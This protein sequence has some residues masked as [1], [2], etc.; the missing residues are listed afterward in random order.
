M[1]QDDVNE[2]FKALAFRSMADDLEQIMNE[3]VRLE[4]Q[5]RHHVGC[6]DDP[7]AANRAASEAAGLFMTVTLAAVPTLI[8]GLADKFN[9]EKEA[10]LALLDVIYHGAGEVR[11]AIHH[12]EQG[13]SALALAYLHN[14]G[15]RY[16]DALEEAP[17]QR[18]GEDDE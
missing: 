14:L 8:M 17:Y 5:A 6:E 11:A 2:Q 12:L 15:D 16:A 13:Q 7:D 18:T 4:A 9:R 3:V 10:L 1:N